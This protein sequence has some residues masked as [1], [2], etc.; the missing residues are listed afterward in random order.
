M[1]PPCLKGIKIEFSCVCLCVCVQFRILFSTVFRKMSL[2]SLPSCY[3]SKPSL[4]FGAGSG[5]SP[6]LADLRDT[7]RPR[8][9]A[10][11]S[12][13]VGKVG[14]ETRSL[15]SLFIQSKSIA[16]VPLSPGGK[17]MEG[18]TQWH[19]SPWDPPRA[20]QSRLGTTPF[21]AVPGRCRGYH[22]SGH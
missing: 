1:C 4:G 13:R 12:V 8:T 5:S 3:D 10:S 15:M 6:C 21:A 14:D 9:S 7:W 16:L 11:S 19:S 22:E 2:C 20:E 18:K 17:R